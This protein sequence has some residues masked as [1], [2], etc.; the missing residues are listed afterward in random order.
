M[1]LPGREDWDYSTMDRKSTYVPL[2]DVMM[3]AETQLDM[4]MSPK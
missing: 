4:G 2:C 1:L 3:Q